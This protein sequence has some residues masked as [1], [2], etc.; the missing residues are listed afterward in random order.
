MASA[1]LPG[2]VEGDDSPCVVRATAAAA[3]SGWAASVAAA[4]ATCGEPD[5][6]RGPSPVLP[7]LCT[8]GERTGGRRLRALAGRPPEEAG[9]PLEEA[10]AAAVAGDSDS[11]IGVVTL[12]LSLRPL[13]AA[14]PPKMLSCA[15]RGRRGPVLITC[16]CGYRGCSEP[17]VPARRGAR[18]FSPLPLPPRL[19]PGLDGTRPDELLAELELELE[20]TLFLPTRATD[21]R[22]GDADAPA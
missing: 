11:E 6:G 22:R 17:P 4:A 3:A 1:S 16:C 2:A 12:L 15:A 7:E 13:V 9:R 19:G 20:L 10:T 8:R 5:S 21:S 14:S 18:P